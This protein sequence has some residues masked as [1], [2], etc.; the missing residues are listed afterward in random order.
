[1]AGGYYPVHGQQVQINVDRV[2]ECVNAID[3]LLAMVN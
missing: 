3:A 1:M 2:T